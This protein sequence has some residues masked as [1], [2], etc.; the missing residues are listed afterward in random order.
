MA[1]KAESKGYLCRIPFVPFLS[2]NCE[3]LC[4]YLGIFGI[5]VC[6][7]RVKTSIYAD[8]ELWEKFKL[9]MA[10][11]GVEVVRLLRS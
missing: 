5:G 11:R 2:L 1:H 9:E 6:T 7:A 4:A 10:K 8:K 3:S